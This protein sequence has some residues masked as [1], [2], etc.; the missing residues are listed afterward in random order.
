MSSSPIHYRNLLL[1]GVGLPAVLVVADQSLLNILSPA[2]LSGPATGVLI[3]FYAMQIALMGWAL[4]RYVTPWPLR[5]FIW[6]WTMA[7]IDLQLAVMT[8]SVYTDAMRCLSTGVLAGQIGALLV[9]GILGSGLIVWR[10]P[11]LLALLIVCANCYGLLL[12][13]GQ[14]TA[15]MQLSW[16]DL[17]AVEGV[18]LAALCI[19]LRLRGYWLKAEVGDIHSSPDKLEVSR[20]L[21]FG[22]RD[23]LIGTTSLAVLL[24]IAKSGDFLKLQFVRQMYDGGFLLVAT[25]AIA[26]AAVLLIAIWSALGRGPMELR[27]LVLVLA[28]LAVGGPL[29]WYSVNIGQPKMILNRDYRFDHW[30]QTGYWWIGWMFVTATLL[31]ASL[32]IFRT[33]GYR[34]VRTPKGMKGR[35]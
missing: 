12:R 15:W 5:W 16:S 19:G 4:A 10:I 13:V 26:T 14:N 23:L 32:I 24:G 7:L 30:Y 25:V 17:L 18:A 11:A 20:S 28:S 22:I 8:N 2:R 6:T 9:W 27:V 33:L 34:L 21:Q 35:D 31:A 1:V 29:A 3:S